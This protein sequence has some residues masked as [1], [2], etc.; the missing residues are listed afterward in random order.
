[1][2]A[3]AE[4]AVDLTVN[5]AEY[6][7]LLLSFDLLDDQMRGRITICGNFD[8]VIRQMRE[9]IDCKAPKLQ[10]LRHKTMVKLRSWPTHQFLHMK[11]DWN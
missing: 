6:R 10:L 9:E 11:R 5:E 4:Y 3:T 7:G 8:S 1:M 2:T